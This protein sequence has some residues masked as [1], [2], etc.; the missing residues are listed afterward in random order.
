MTG[1]KVKRLNPLG[2]IPELI[3]DGTERKNDTYTFSYDIKK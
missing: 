3:G 2:A 1:S